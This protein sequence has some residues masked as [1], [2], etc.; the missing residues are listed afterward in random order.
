MSTEDVFQC[1]FLAALLKISHMYSRNF[2]LL[3]RDKSVFKEFVL[4]TNYYVT[5][6]V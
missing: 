3:H 4:D 2:M 5:L 1:L 6:K